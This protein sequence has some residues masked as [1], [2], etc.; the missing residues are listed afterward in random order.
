MQMAGPFNPFRQSMMPQQTGFM[1][2]QPTGFPSQFIQPQ[3]TGQMA[4]GNQQP[5][6]TGPS[7]FGQPQQT[8]PFQSQ[9][10]IQPQQT[11]FQPAI[12]QPAPLQPHSTGP[13]PFRQTMM[14]SNNQVH[15]SGILSQ[16]T[17][18][19]NGQAQIPRPGS[20]PALNTLGQ[21]GQTNSAPTASAKNPFA[22]TGGI[23]PAAK[24]KESAGPS[25]NQLAWNKA[26]SQFGAMNTQQTGASPWASVNGKPSTGF[27]PQPTGASPWASLNGKPSSPGEG[28]TGISDIASSFA[29]ES[30]PSSTS[31]FL[32]QFG[33]LSVNTNTTGTGASSTSPVG[34]QF[35]SISSNPTGSTSPTKSAGGI[36]PQPTGYGGSAVKRFQPTSS[37]GS[38]LLESL[39][40]IS[41]PTSPLER[42][43]SASAQAQPGMPGQG[44]T[45]AFGQN[46]GG[47]FGGAG[48]G[49]NPIPG[50]MQ[51]QGTG[52]PN[53]FRQSTFG[54]GQG[55]GSNPTGPSGFGAFGPGSPFAG[56]NRPP[57]AGAFGQPF[58]GAPFGQQPQQNQNQP[59]Q[60]GPFSQPFGQQQQQQSG[61]SLI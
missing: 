19:I 17:S 22:P 15:P 6:Q 50:G 9:P 59:F 3:M 21:S 13:N 39:P 1:Q 60:S 45:P 26:Q 14:F 18:P 28:P 61:G 48:Q 42:P 12:Q 55:Q 25:M 47:A 31:D 29:V 46:T 34:T 24:P 16:P 57:A 7:P 56:Q 35:G 51:A 54:L 44:S 53:P 10:F 30:K 43:G 11:A 27:N 40:S 33:S 37:F 23:Q 58:G 38:Q 41:E 49:Q 32:S 8:G 36:Q 2:S 5:F 52:L 20:T 4:F